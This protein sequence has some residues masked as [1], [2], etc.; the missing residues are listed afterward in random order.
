MKKTKLRKDRDTAAANGD[1]EAVADLDFQLEELEK[2]AEELDKK[3]EGSLSKVKGINSRNRR[4][5]VTRA[6][7]G[8]KEEASRKAK[9]E[10]DVLDPFTRRKT[11][12]VMFQTSKVEK[13]VESTIIDHLSQKKATK[14]ENKIGIKKI[15]SIKAEQKIG[16]SKT[17][18]TVETWPDMFTAHN[19]DLD[20][21]IG[22]TPSPSLS[23]KPSKEAGKQIGPVKKSVKI[24]EWKKR[25]GIV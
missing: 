12:P 9:E 24:E 18:G 7:M 16:T 17:S 11:V 20:I 15:S 10:A 13:K 8:I 19:F 2:R 5:N 21:D 25:K 22:H 1:D 23:V 14:E 3:R 6:E 4:N